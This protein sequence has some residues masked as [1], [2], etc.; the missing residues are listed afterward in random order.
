MTESEWQGGADP[1]PMLAFLRGRASDRKSRMFALA[2]CR[3]V[4]DFLDPRGVWALDVAE[5]YADGL[6]DR[7]ALE[8]ARAGADEAFDEFDDRQGRESAAHAVEC[9]CHA[10]GLGDVL[11]EIAWDTAAVASLSQPPHLMRAAKRLGRLNRCRLLRDIFNNPFRLVAL[12]LTWLSST[13]VGLAQGIY[14][15]RAF[16]RLPILADALEESGCGDAGL[17]AHCRETGP[18]VRGCWV[19]DLLLDKQ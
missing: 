18:H 8:A 10:D 19:I 16:D 15:D 4:T 12:D 1:T 6:C 14:A 5:R 7:D 13:A 3:F 17:L 2:C 9:L 11:N